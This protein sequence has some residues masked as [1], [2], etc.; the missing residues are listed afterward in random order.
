MQKEYEW[1]ENQCNVSCAPP[2][3]TWKGAFEMK[4]TGKILIAAVL[5]IFMVTLAV[6]SEARRGN[7]RGPG[8][9]SRSGHFKSGHKR[10]FHRGHYKRSPKPR[11]RHGYYGY[12][13]K[14]RYGSKRHHYRSKHYR[15]KGSYRHGFYGRYGYGKYG[16]HRYPYGHRYYYRPY[17]A[18]L[19]YYNAYQDDYRDSSDDAGSDGSI[20]YQEDYARGWN[21]LREDRPAEALQAF[22]HY[23]Q[24]NPSEGMPKVGYALALAELGRLDKGIRAMRR[25]LQENPEA[26]PYMAIDEK[27]RPKVER[28]AA[29]YEQ[30]EQ[31]SGNDPG[32][33]FMLA[34]LY[35]LLDDMDTAQKAMERNIDSY[36]T[37]TSAKNLKRLIEEETQVP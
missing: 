6:E 29:R 27:L 22:G 8:N 37:S 18:S 36:D 31:F 5:S 3:N 34:A 2:T 13:A 21:L 35:Y 25:A 19:Y 20:D 4:A 17:P 7:Y 14:H 15:P 12:G 30:A 24:A 26:L 16:Y 1:Q 9:L 32:G 33:S 23:A 28:T 11:Y 10:S